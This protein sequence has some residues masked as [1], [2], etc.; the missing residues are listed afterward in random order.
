MKTLALNND[1]III[2]DNNI[3]SEFVFNF[4]F[5]NKYDKVNLEK[6]IYSNLNSID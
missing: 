5:N 1:I 6:Y 2:T 4:L 3:K